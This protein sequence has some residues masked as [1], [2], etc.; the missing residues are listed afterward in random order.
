[1]NDSVLEQ[2]KPRLTVVNN[3]TFL[4]FEN[5]FFLTVFWR[6]KKI[7][8]KRTPNQPIKKKCI[9]IEV[10]VLKYCSIFMSCH[11]TWH[12]ILLSK[13]TRV[14]FCKKEIFYLI[15]YK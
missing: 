11:S 6:F 8:K 13:I 12:F 10:L 4:I 14:I 3:W 1:M 15:L 9:F 2:Q 5:I 7:G